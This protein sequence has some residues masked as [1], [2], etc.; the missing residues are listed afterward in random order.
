MTSA[1][2]HIAFFF[3]GRSAEHE[4]SVNSAR[5]IVAALD[6]NRFTPILVAIDPSGNWFLVT[7]EMLADMKSVTGEAPARRIPIELLP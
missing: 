3:G 1:K 5:N 4:V 2:K 6:R 7:E